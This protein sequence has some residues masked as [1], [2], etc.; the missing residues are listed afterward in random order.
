M[1]SDDVSIYN[2]KDVDLIAQTF[3]NTVIQIWP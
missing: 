3:H 2:K 1:E